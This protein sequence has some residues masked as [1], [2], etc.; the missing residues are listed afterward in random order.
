EDDD[1][2]QPSTSVEAMEADSADMYQGAAYPA[3]LAAVMGDEEQQSD[4]AFLAAERDLVA[5]EPGLY[6]P[7]L[8]ASYRQRW[9]RM[10]VVEVLGTN[11]Y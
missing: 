9:P 7:E 11:H 6:P 10:E 5:A 3:A 4:V 8:V 1:T 2:F